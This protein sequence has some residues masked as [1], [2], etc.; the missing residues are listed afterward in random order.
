MHIFSVIISHEI[1][2][3]YLYYK[4]IHCLPEISIWLHLLYFTRQAYSQGL[5]R[6]AW[7]ANIAKKYLEQGVR[8]YRQLEG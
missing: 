5:L 1:F 8:H 2:N 3:T 6:V 4:S 7:E